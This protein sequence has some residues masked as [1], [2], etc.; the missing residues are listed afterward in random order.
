MP[1]KFLKISSGDSKKRKRF[2]FEIITV[3]VTLINW[4]TEEVISSLITL[5]KRKSK[6]KKDSTGTVERISPWPP[7]KR[8]IPGTKK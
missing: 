8:T 2:V 5:K 3:K 7:A 4:F 1:D 6:A